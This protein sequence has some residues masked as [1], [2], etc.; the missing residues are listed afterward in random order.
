L[1]KLPISE[2]SLVSILKPENILP[3]NEIE[4][5]SVFQLSK[6]FDE[7]PITSFYQEEVKNAY[8]L[9]YARSG[10]FPSFK[11]AEGLWHT[12]AAEAIGQLSRF[13][14]GCGRERCEARHEGNEG[15]VKVGVVA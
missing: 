15:W 4:K 9:L 6:S 12:N 3:D 5:S 2:I 10:N 7:D 14:M 8:P 1:K 11:V 13:E